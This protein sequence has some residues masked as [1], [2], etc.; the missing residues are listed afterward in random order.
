ML[1]ESDICVRHCTEHS[2]KRKENNKIAN[3]THREKAGRQHYDAYAS[4]KQS[5]KKKGNA[6]RI[7]SVD[8]FARAS[9]TRCP[10]GAKFSAELRKHWV[11]SFSVCSA[12]TLRRFLFCQRQSR[13]RGCTRQPPDVVVVAD[14]AGARARA[15]LSRRT[16]CNQKCDTF[17]LKSPPAYMYSLFRPSLNRTTAKACG[18]DAERMFGDFFF[19]LNDPSE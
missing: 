11:S 10:P 8:A 18:F 15:S 14:A 9:R 13:K 1:Q 2:R 4:L 6:R 12:G 3:K 17:P 19:L 7:S 16:Q 5:E